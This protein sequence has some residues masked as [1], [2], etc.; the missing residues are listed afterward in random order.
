MVSNGAE[1]IAFGSG[2]SGEIQVIE[3]TVGDQAYGRQSWRR[4]E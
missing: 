3:L 2:A 1:D 4:L